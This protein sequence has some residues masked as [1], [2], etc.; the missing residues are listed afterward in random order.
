MTLTTQS[1]P[2]SFSR[3]LLAL[4]ASLTLSLGALPAMSQ[5][6]APATQAEPAPA[7]APAG[8]QDTAAQAR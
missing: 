5:D 3:V 6:P 4:A 1:L 7:D 2:K 8:A